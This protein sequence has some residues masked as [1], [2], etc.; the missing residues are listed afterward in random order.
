MMIAGPSNG[1]KKA[2]SIGSARPMTIDSA[3][4]I[5]PWRPKKAEHRHQSSQSRHSD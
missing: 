2:A 3:T 4:A 5:V 1:L